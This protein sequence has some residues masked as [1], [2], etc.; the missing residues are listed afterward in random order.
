[1]FKKVIRKYATA[2]K[3]IKRLLWIKTSIVLNF[4]L[5]ELPVK[6]LEILQNKKMKEKHLQ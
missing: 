4:K 6:K 5:G 2:E 1:M 3:R